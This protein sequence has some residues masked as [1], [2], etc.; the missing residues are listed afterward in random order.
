MDYYTTVLNPV[1]YSPASDG[2]DIDYVWGRKQDFDGEIIWIGLSN[3]APSIFKSSLSGCISSL[4]FASTKEQ[5]QETTWKRNSINV[6]Q[7]IRSPAPIYAKRGDP[8]ARSLAGIRENPRIYLNPKA[9]TC[10]W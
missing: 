3:P 7:H 10:I 1:G 5:Q 8:T 4:L 9:V 6:W 2:L